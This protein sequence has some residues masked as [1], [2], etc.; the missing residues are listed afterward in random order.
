MLKTADHYSG[1]RLD[2]L[3]DIIVRYHRESPIRRIHSTKIGEIEGESLSCRTGDHRPEGLFFV[4]GPG[5]RSGQLN[6]TFSAMDLAPTMAALLG[7]ELPDVDGEP[8]A[9]LFRDTSVTAIA[10]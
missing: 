4:S 2:E 5:L 10:D 3:S 1:D 9:T 7:L 8:I 6:Q